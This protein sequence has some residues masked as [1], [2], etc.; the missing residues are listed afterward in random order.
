MF[1]VLGITVPRGSAGG[2][3]KA[4]GDQIRKSGFLGA[5]SGKPYWGLL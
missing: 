4:A 3:A 1:V 2:L 5:R